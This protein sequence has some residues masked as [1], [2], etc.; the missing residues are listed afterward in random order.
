MKGKYRSYT[1]D[2][3]IKYAKKVKSIA[4][5][6]RRLG[7]T[8]AGGNYINIKRLL[9]KLNIDCSNWTGQGWNKNQQLKDWSKY[10][11]I[12]SIKRQLIL[13]RGHQCEKCKRKKWLRHL[14]PLEIDHVD[15]D[16]TN[17]KKDNLKL[18]CCNCHALTPTWRGRSSKQREKI[19]LCKNC[20]CKISLQSKSGLCS[21]CFNKSKKI[22]FKGWNHV[23]YDQTDE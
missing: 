18:L 11:K 13:E 7:L 17:N 19:I 22:K 10:T 15:G 1:D 8:P 5:L 23:S 4:G 9:Q 12:D 21:S 20:N 16:R 6:L 14:I 3:I 2:D